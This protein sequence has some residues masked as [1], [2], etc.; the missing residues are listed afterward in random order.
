MSG[1]GDHELDHAG[2]VGV[3]LEHTLDT[4]P[5]PTL[6]IGAGPAPGA[7]LG[8]MLGPTARAILMATYGACTP[9]P[10]MSLHLEEE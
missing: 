7:N 3:S 2:K 10:Q 6:E 4:D 9:G 8:V 5:G 1:E